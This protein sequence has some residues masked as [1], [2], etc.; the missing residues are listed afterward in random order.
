[1]DTDHANFPQTA[2][3]LPAGDRVHGFRVLGCAAPRNDNGQEIRREAMVSV[4]ELNDRR[5]RTPERP[6]VVIC[7]DGCDPEYLEAA[8]RTAFFRR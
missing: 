8:F 7:V 1:M 3:S 5:Y 6:T 4:I 2:V